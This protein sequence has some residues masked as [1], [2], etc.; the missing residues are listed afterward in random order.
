MKIIFQYNMSVNIQ[1]KKM[2]AFFSF[3]NVHLA[4]CEIKELLM[5]HW[6]ALSRDDADSSD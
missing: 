5:A 1:K 4:F 2:T 6:T 3:I